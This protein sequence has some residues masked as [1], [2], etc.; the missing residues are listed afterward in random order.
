MPQLLYLCPTNNNPA[1]HT[2][3]AASREAL[4]AVVG[5]TNGSTAVVATNRGPGNV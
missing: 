5:S 1:G 3:P 4:V 2:L